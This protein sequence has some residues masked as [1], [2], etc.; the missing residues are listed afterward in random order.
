MVVESSIE[1]REQRR[2]DHLERG[3]A[4]NRHER[5]PTERLAARFHAAFVVALAGP[6]ETRLEQVVRGERRETRC[7]RAL[8]ADQDPYDG[9]AQI[10]VGHPSRHATEVREGAHVP[11]E[12]TD[13]ILPLVDPRE[14]AAGIHQ[15]HQEQ[16]R[17]AAGAGEIDQHLEEIDLGRDRPADTS[18]AQ[19]PRA[20]AAA[21]RRPPLS[22]G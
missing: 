21:T 20:A 19:T 14:V 7:Q 16:P 18:T 8:A 15:P 10:V 1:V 6:A 5:L 2:I 3:A 9:R 17:L 13:L 22:R 12:K 4:R 11:I